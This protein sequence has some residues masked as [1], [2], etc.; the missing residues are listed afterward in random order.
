M[1]GPGLGHPTGVQQLQRLEAA[2]AGASGRGAL[3][4]LAQRQQ[5]QAT[6]SG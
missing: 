3:T 2:V 4:G 5:R 6:A 1:T